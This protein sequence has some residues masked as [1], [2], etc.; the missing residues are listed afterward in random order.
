[1]KLSCFLVDAGVGQLG[2]GGEE[3]EVSEPRMMNELPEAMS[4]IA[5][6][7][8]S[9]GTCLIIITRPLLKHEYLVFKVLQTSLLT[10]IL[11]SSSI[12]LLQHVSLSREHY[13]CGDSH[14]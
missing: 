1:M 11:S 4:M 14:T 5:A 7:T 10:I 12:N 13:T 9:S 3:K 2:L 6:S 8:V